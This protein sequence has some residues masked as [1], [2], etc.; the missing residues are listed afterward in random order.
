MVNI[1]IYRKIPKTGFTLDPVISG[2]FLKNLR[3][4]EPLHL[5]NLC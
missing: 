1:L 2:F 5:N 3:T 4:R